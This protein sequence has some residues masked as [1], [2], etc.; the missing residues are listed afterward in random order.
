MGNC[1]HL[2][3]NVLPCTVEESL[4]NVPDADADLFQNLL[5]SHLSKDNIF[6]KIFILM[7]LVAFT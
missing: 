6:C 2:W 3:K 4:K 1:P 7:R 5:V